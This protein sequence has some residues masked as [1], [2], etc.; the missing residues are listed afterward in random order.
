MA[1]FLDDLSVYNAKASLVI[2]QVVADGDT[3]KANMMSSLKTTANDTTLSDA[4][5]LNALTALINLGSLLDVPLPPY[6]PIV[7]T[8]ANTQTYVGI[9]NDLSGIQGGVPGEY[10]HLTLAE[11]T[12]ALNAATQADITFA[13]LSGVYSDNASLVTAFQGKQNALSGTGF[14]RISGTTIS[15]DN[16]TYL[17]TISGIA[18]G[19]ELSGTYPN[20]ALSNAAVISKVLT[21]FTGVALPT[22]ITSSDTILSAMQKLNNNI[23]SL[24]VSPSGV[25]SVALTTNAGGVFTTT[26]S[27]QTG[28]ATLNI[29]LNS[30][31]ANLFLASPNG[32]SG[33]PSFR[34][35]VA[36][37]L[38][39]SG[40]TA[41]TYGSSSFIP[42]IVVDA[43]GRITS[44]S[45]V[46]AA[47][48]G[49]VNTV[50]LTQPGIFGAVTNIGT[51][52][53]VNLNY[54]LSTQIANYVWAGPVSGANAV[55]TF[56]ALVVADVPDLPT[57]KITGLVSILNGF[58][59]DSLSDG[60]IWIGNT[61]NAAV[62][63]VL[64]GDVSVSNLGVT[65]IG[66]AKVQYNMIQDVTTQT[67]LGRYDAVDGEVQQVTLSGD[68]L[69]NSSTGVLSLSSP[70]SPVV[71]TKGDL[72]GHDLTAQQRV[73]SSNVDG[74]ILL[75][76]N[77]ATG[78]YTD[79]GLNWVTMSGDATI[80][81]SGA[82]TIAAG[83]VTLAKMA[84]LAN[85]R[86]IGNVSGGAAAPSAL[87][88]TQVTGMLDLFSTS[89]QG[90]VPA[91]GGGTVN[92]LRADGSWQAPPGGG[93]GSGTVSP[94][95]EYE[96]A[97]YPSA[98]TTV[99]G[100]GVGT[101]G[102]FLKSGGSAAAPSWQ[103]VTGTGNVVLANSPTL[104]TP[105]LGAAL[106]TSINGLIITSTTGTLTLDNGSILATSGAFSTTLTA[107]ATT[108]LTLPTTGT[109]ATLAGTETFT[110][111]TLN[112]PKIGTVGGQGHFHMHFANSAPT[113]LTD[114]I[115]VF[116]DVAPTKKL[117]F[118]FELD[119]F[120]SYFQ[121]NA[122]TASKTYTFP[123]L[124][125]TV[126]LLANPAAFTS[127]TTGTASSLAG[128]VIFQ[129]ATNATT[130]TFRGT[131][132]TSSIVYLLPTTAPTAGQAL[133]STVPSAGIATL[134][135]SS[136]SGAGVTTVGAFS[137]SAQTNGANITGTTITF[138]P[139]SD[140]IPGMVSTGVQTFAGVKTFNS[141]IIFGSSAA[142]PTLTTRSSGTKLVLNPTLTSGALDY[143]WGV[144]LGTMWGTLGGPADQ[145]ILYYP[146]GVV[147]TPFLT[148]TPATNIIFNGSS[149]T[150]GTS[151]T[152]TNVRGG[153][154]D[155]GII[156][157]NF[158][159]LGTGGGTAA[160][161]VVGAS[162]VARS[163]GSRVIIQS[164]STTTQA[165][166]AIG[167]NTNE[168]WMSLFTNTSATSF[169]WYGAATK[170]M[171]LRGDGLLTLT[172][173]LALRAGAA[174]AGSAP[175]AFTSGTN[176]TTPVNGSM[177]YN[178][179]NLFFTRAGA[180][181]EGVLTQSAVTTEVLVSD[182][183]VT[184]NIGGTTYKLLAK[185]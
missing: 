132:P 168:M 72:L 145:F 125:G 71:S 171:T 129:N 81:A 17:T 14:V 61:S 66:L 36:A 104:V 63:R 95:A 97:Y 106:A 133:V 120:E 51:A 54:G 27:P 164:T 48:G 64:S 108:T 5:R 112:G 43:K 169:G 22:P 165:D 184:I 126:A 58:L 139:A 110:N 113:G 155:T 122:T 67:L 156:S 59:T 68:F 124:S 49:Q 130:Q 19:G 8:Y 32:S 65:A 37:D 16:S 162:W 45:S 153:S 170:I 135:W 115:T 107:T 109:L 55:P 159:N 91:S 174:A 149:I 25:A 123:D 147:V 35:F 157:R 100:L 117:G 9:H 96:L 127:I 94:G 30:Q 33:T 144:G 23:S 181:R 52:S 28:A 101:A 103:A 102:Y 111:K 121:F 11:R 152:T 39:N 93:G 179:T 40:A 99:D 7:T 74:D 114:Y 44:I 34:A 2:S 131:N 41:G 161:A 1:D 13:N 76:N 50:T 183:S 26:T 84:N 86:I 78:A 82:I 92:F 178:G 29:S 89:V 42:Q 10:Y 137:A 3:G 62:Q 136:V 177:E 150:L 69:L 77:S 118:L 18:A 83:A 172:G 116:G 88:G 6:F 87:T 176:L 134:S 70:V 56:R 182:T 140:T 160:P 31:S 98:G 167:Y 173:T 4:I 148:V 15:Y 57:S 21:G 73:P 163:L 180:V 105:T 90:V 158:I 47:A 151:T 138:G 154:T 85:N 79:L 185:A 24:I 141:N 142:A 46:S 53:N 75:V 146:N 12:Q 119:V 143:A 80:V 175:L 20:P 60:S 166:M 38:P 128:D